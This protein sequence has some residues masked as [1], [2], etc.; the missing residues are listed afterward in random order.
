LFDLALALGCT[1][2]ELEERLTSSEL[3]EWKA[4]HALAPIGGRRGDLQTALLAAVLANCHRDSKAKP[5]PYKIEDFLLFEDREE[6]PAQSQAEQF[7]MARMALGRR[8]VVE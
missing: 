6:Q 8:V 1:V 5:S 7:A 4:Y 3:Q 2:R